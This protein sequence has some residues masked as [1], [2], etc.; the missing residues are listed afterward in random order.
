MLFHSATF[1][2]CVTGLVALYWISPWQRVRLVLLFLGSLVFYGWR[3]WPS[4]FLLLGSIAVNYTLGRLLERRRS[5]AL[6]AR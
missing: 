3:H 4:V 5:K 2:I 1:L 6:L